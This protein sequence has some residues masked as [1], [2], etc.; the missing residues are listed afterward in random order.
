ME[1]V[2][3]AI[4][5]AILGNPNEVK[6]NIFSSLHDKITDALDLKKISVATE[7]FNDNDGA[8]EQEENQPQ[9][10]ETDGEDISTN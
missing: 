6:N 10:V 7:L 9:E 4:N 2:K 3:N 1:S 8:L 5:N